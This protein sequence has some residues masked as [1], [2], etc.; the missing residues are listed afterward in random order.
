MKQ[1]SI[2]L[3]LLCC[4]CFN[5]M[6]QR[7]KVGLVLGGGG[8]KGA[9]HIGV[10]K[11][12]EEAGIP[13]DYIAGTSIGSI[14][15]GLYSIGYTTNYMDS[16]F[17]HQDWKFLLSDQV[18]RR[19][20]SFAAKEMR[21]KFLVSLPF[22]KDE[23]T[24]LP[25]G[26]VSG[27][28]IYN[29]F[30]DMTIGY[31][32]MNSF[33]SLPIPFACVAVDL[34]SGRPV[35]MN[36]GSLPLAMRASMSIPGVFAPVETDG[37]VLVD[38]GALNNLPTNVVRDMGADILIGIDLST[39]NKSP[40]QLKTMLGMVDQLTNIMGAENYRQNKA[41]IDLYFNPDLKGYS[42]A[43]F[44]SDEIRI[45]M[46][47]GEREARAKWDDILLLKK[48]I[49]ADAGQQ[50]E[51]R[52][53]PVNRPARSLP[54]SLHIGCIRFMGITPDSEAWIRKS[55][56]LQENSVITIKEIDDAVGILYGT[57]L[58]TRVEYY[59]TDGKPAD[60]LFTLQPRPLNK[61]NIG[62]R[63][64]SEDIASLLLNATLNRDFMRGITMS[65]T[66]RLSKN[67]YLLLSSHAG[68]DFSQKVGL[69]YLLR[70]NDFRLY[71]GRKKIDNLTFLS[72]SADVSYLG[73]YHSLKFKVGL[74]YDFFSY[75]DYLYDMHS[76]P[77]E[78]SP[79]GFFGYFA[80][81]KFDNLDQKYYPTKGLSFG[82]G[83]EVFTDNLITYRDKSPFAALTINFDTAIPLL[84]RLCLLPSLQARVLLGDNIPLI[85]RNY[86]G[87]DM[88]TRY[89]PQQMSFAGVKYV[90]AF[91]DAVM[92]GALAFRY[93][94]GSNHYLSA[95]GAYARESSR[96]FNLFD[97]KSL[98]ATSVRYSYNSIIGPIAFELN[99]SDRVEKL[100]AYVS[101]GYDF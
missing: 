78:V 65:A 15:G 69:S 21:E 47:R 33:D 93:R 96:F 18:Q 88:N 3:L 68:I 90:Q 62:L 1:R 8:A 67:P 43:S 48:R 73:V 56:Q 91:D 63:F 4:L 19:H 60:L 82:V 17:R 85:Y 25:A 44:T 22:S 53:I 54:D 74:R 20:R 23:K 36:K 42:S 59:T 94:I 26:F 14:V 97:G 34:V 16:M 86:M 9:A 84:Q 72:Q 87:G 10:L 40:G 70:Y 30:S 75:T 66:G 83:G 11:V 57:D 38:G 24:E 79:E 45:M 51:V 89:L 95:S 2:L 55:I 52:D 31:H 32:Y 35:V 49:Y 46:D 61:L 37:M 58:F 64:D 6:A 7:K 29:L 81:L 71:A 77:A 99:Y 13:I 5:G 50:E 100:G 27:Q 28:N 76:Q 80:S 92:Q 41:D 101:L 98:W 39:G 12:L